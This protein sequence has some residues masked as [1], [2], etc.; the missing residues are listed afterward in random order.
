MS[1]KHRRV[2]TDLKADRF[3]LMLEENPDHYQVMNDDDE[4]PTVIWDKW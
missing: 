3:W 4:Q 1:K 2:G